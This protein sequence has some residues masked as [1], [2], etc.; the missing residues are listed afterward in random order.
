[1]KF[2]SV[3]PVTATADAVKFADGLLSVN[4][5]VAESAARTADVLV[6]ITTCGGVAAS[7]AS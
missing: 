4:V 7:H 2:E 6:A 3:P 5:T 1:M